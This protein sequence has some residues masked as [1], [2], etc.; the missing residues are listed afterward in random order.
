MLHSFY[1]T[2]PL[3]FLHSSLPFLDSNIIWWQVQF[4]KLYI[5]QFSLISYHFQP[6]DSKTRLALLTN[7]AYSLCS[8]SQTNCYTH[9]YENTG[10]GRKKCPIW[11]ANKFKT[12]EDKANV[13]FYFW[14]VHRMPFYINVFWTKHHSSVYCA[15]EVEMCLIRKKHNICDA[16]V[17]KVMTQLC[18]VF[19]ITSLQFLCNHYFVGMHSQISV[20]NSPHTSVR[21]Q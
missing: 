15:R 4:M 11:E 7:P 14:K 1:M 10:C 18:T 5:M 9:S 13:F 3:T 16:K 8:M 21:R 20:Q 17:Q 12:K 2:K 6:W 19:K